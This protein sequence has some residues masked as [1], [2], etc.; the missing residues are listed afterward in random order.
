MVCFLCEKILLSL[1]HPPRHQ[2]EEI[3]EKDAGDESGDGVKGVVCLDIYS[4]EEHQDK[5]EDNEI[6]EFSAAAMPC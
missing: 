6:E 5:Q 4:G 2:E 3:V 1:N